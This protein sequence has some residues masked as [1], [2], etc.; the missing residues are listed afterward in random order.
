M[1]KLVTF[2]MQGTKIFE[3]YAEARAVK[4]E[5]NMSAAQ[6][7]I[8]KQVPQQFQKMIERNVRRTT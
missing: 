5:I 3:W 8:Q 4:E 2:P 1:G 6:V 7:W